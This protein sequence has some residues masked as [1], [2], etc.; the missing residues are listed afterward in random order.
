M[1]K[2]SKQE[3]EMAANREDESGR[4][5]FYSALFSQLSSHAG[6]SELIVWS[7]AGDLVPVFTC[8]SGPLDV[9]SADRE[10]D[11]GLAQRALAS[12][13]TVVSKANGEAGSNS[14]RTEAFLALDSI[15]VAQ[16]RFAIDRDH[17]QVDESVASA[18]RVVES[19]VRQ[20][21]APSAAN[22]MFDGRLNGHELELERND[23]SSGHVST[24]KVLEFFRN[25]GQSLDVKSVAFNV[26]NE[27][28]QITE[29]DRVSVF[30]RRGRNFSALS[31]SGVTVVN[32]RS[33]EIRQLQKLVS[34]T[35]VLRRTFVYPTE[36]SSTL[37][38][39]VEAA[40]SS[41][42]A[43]QSARSV[44]VIP[45]FENAQSDADDPGKRREL[46]RTNSV[47][48]AIAIEHFQ[49]QVDS[50]SIEQSEK[51]G[52]CAADSFRNALCHQRLFL[53]PVWSFLG[54]AY[55]FL[56][57]RH[58]TGT[59]IGCFAMVALS[60]AALFW[61]A[62]YRL[63]CRGEL[64]PELSRTIYAEIDGLVSE[65][66]TDTGNSVE[67]GQKLVRLENKELLI[68]HQEL[69]GNM[70][71]L[72][73]RI[74]SIDRFSVGDPRNPGQD[75]GNR[76]QVAMERSGLEKQVET[77]RKQLEIVDRQIQMQDITSPIFGEVL[78]PNLN[79]ELA[80]R[81]VS[82]GATLLDVAATSGEW[83]L[84]LKLPDRKIGE[85]LKAQDSFS[86][87]LEVTFILASEPETTHSGKVKAIEL[88]TQTDD[89]I[90]QYLQVIVD[91]DEAS[92]VDAKVGS[93]VI[94]YVKCGK[95]SL[96]F[97]WTKD[98]VDFVRRRVF[99]PFW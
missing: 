85:L 24:E 53:Y 38:K 79:R 59:A 46:Q 75:S 43:D 14:R 42:L 91:V 77:I 56:I 13:R 69:E 72:L 12:K 3:L 6:V 39:S 51:F 25:I 36:I 78:T 19:L 11:R 96:G 67:K 84:D 33:K 62:E 5:L 22:L 80:D 27:L 45:V 16:I 58:F 71:A 1:A 29:S 89:D 68:R 65:V 98:V 7:G 18:Q 97:I 83:V 4:S 35:S 31:A 94:A 92:F 90:G 8:S 87:S 50:E 47:V 73:E 2:T 52:Q 49:S 86:E 61:Q 48:G 41:Y 81:P 95:R 66:F 88:T 63:S 34:E 17:S 64:R 57:G 20:T 93:E 23:Q 32:R 99:F 60:L 82:R 55:D 30:R 28:R 26:A 21:A 74:E 15:H 10:K 40:L 70:S 76:E 37:S 44:V 54:R 9:V